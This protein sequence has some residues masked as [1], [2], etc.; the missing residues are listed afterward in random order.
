M[1]NEE[2]VSPTA[3]MCD[4]FTQANLVILPKKDALDFAIYAQRNPKPL[5]LLDIAEPGDYE[6]KLMAPNADLRTDL[7]KYRVYKKGNVTDEPLNIKK[8]WQ[9]D[10]VAFLIGC[11]FTF[12]RALIDAGIPIRHREE[13]KNV[14]L[15]N[16]N[17]DTI[18]GGTFKGPMVV[19][20][21]PI[22]YKK[23]VKAVQVTSRFPSVHGAPIHIGD[24]PRIG[25]TD[26]DDPDFGDA[27]TIREGE[28]PVFWG[29]GVTAQ[30]AAMKAKPEMMIT[31]YPGHMFITS[32]KDKEYSVL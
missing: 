12:E 20:M 26:L 24:P 3:G 22:H 32:R 17:K 6:P 28:I 18:P 31:H 14:P 13:G 29:C 5:P 16:T 9:D 10:F 7:P 1:R 19:S 30:L 4:G 25:I 23:V 27:V 11:S 2:L 15:Y 8:Y 21:R